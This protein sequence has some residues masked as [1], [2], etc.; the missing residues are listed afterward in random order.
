MMAKI[1]VYKLTKSVA[2]DNICKQLE[3]LSNDAVHAKTLTNLEIS[4]L[5]ASAVR[6]LNVFETLSDAGHTDLSADLGSK[7]DVNWDDHQQT[8]A[9]LKATHLKGFVSFVKANESEI[10]K[11]AF[12]NGNPVYTAISVE[13]KA[14]LL[15]LVTAISDAV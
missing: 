14:L 13:T 8:F 2:V 11:Q 5:Y 1:P 9:D 3:L 4:R 10:L 15:P 12:K 6:A 7:L